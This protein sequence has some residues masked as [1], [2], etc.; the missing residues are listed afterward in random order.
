[1]TEEDVAMLARINGLT[2]APEYL[3]GVARN[4]AVLEEQIALLTAPPL[5]AEIEPAPVFR[6]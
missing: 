2:I 1:M 5:D 3:P 4:L 6:P